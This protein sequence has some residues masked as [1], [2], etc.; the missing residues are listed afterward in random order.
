MDG[1][2]YPD[3][4]VDVETTG[5]TPHACA[6][7]QIGAVPFNYDTGAIDTANMFKISLTM[8]K[9]RYWTDDT[10]RFWMVD[11]AEVYWQIMEQAQP[12]RE[13]FLSFHQWA[14]VRGDVR[15]W[16]KGMLDWNMIESYC[17]MYDLDMPFNFRQVKDLRSFVAGLYGEAEYREP[18][19]EKVGNHHDA[20][21]DALTQLRILFKAK[22][23]TCQSRVVTSA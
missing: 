18:E 11:N 8:P 16:S 7:I 6:L 9:T 10:Q 14:Q 5:L 4:M 3:V 1:I 12:H 17:K 15:F 23:E 19:V 21:H 20:L 2:T 22:E 13:A